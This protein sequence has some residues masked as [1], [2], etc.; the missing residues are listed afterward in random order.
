MAAAPSAPTAKPAVVPVSPLPCIASG[1]GV[2]D[3]YATCHAQRDRYGR[4]TVTIALTFVHDWPEL[5]QSGTA[6]RNPSLAG[7]WLATLNDLPE[8]WDRDPF[9]RQLNFR[10]AALYAYAVTTKDRDL[11][12][13]PDLVCQST[14]PDSCRSHPP[15]PNFRGYRN[16]ARLQT[17]SV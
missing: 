9:W 5:E 15:Q 14:D 8:W 3:P 1:P 6:S 2:T 12:L 17:I 7:R 16:A 13:Q 4:D 10:I 11:F